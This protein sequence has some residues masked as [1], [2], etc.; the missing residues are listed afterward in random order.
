VRPSE[1]RSDVLATPSLSDEKSAR[2]HFREIRAFSVTTAIILTPS[3]QPFSQFASL[4]A[5]EEG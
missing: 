3:S 4:I 5:G 1:E 2:S